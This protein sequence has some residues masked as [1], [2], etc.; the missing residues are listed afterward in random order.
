MFVAPGNSRFDPLISSNN[1]SPN[2]ESLHKLLQQA[3]GSELKDE[4]VS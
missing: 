2:N 1:S 4:G 3:E